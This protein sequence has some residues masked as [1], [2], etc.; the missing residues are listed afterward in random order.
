MAT[1]KQYG[2][3]D[4]RTFA[5]A[6][7]SGS[8]IADITRQMNVPRA[9]VQSWRNSLDQGVLVVTKDAVLWDGAK[10]DEKTTQRS[11]PNAL[12]KANKEI[13]KLKA[14]NAKLKESI[15]NHRK[16][17]VKYT[18][19][20]CSKQSNSFLRVVIPDSHGCKADQSAIN[21]FLADLEQLDKVEE[22]VWL[23]D[24]LDCDGFLTTHV[25]QYIGQYDYSFEEDVDAANGFLDAV[26]KRTPKA[27]H[28]YL[29]GNH[30][31]RI[32]RWI[33]D[34]VKTSAKDASYLYRLMGPETVLGLKERGITFFNQGGYHMGIKTRGFIKL[35]ECYFTHGMSTNGQHASYKNLHKYAGCIVHGHNHTE[36]QAGTRFVEGRRVGAW[37]PGCLCEPGPMYRHSNASNATHGYAFQT[38]YRD[39]TFHHVNV[40]LNDG[41][42][43]L[44]DL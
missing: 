3:S 39:G 22:V 13:E 24:H 19:R 16:P 2:A 21:A 38:V 20:R 18:G 25:R 33:C 35:G 9:T 43:F 17:K 5:E 36:M 41:R 29:E 6:Y 14:E 42:S 32:E 28:Y 31:W 26:Q 23:G 30:E 44:A 37:C 34:Q 8:T 1:R 11:D 4:Y 7:Q 27:K 10:L 15:E 40:P 12:K